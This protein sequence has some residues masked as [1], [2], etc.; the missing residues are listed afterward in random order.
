MKLSEVDLPGQ[1]FWMFLRSFRLRQPI[2]RFISC[3]Y[4]ST[5]FYLRN[6]SVPFSLL[7]LDVKQ[8]IL[9]NEKKSIFVV[10]KAL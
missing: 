6:T 9:R 7:L 10:P 2:D 3:K 8:C 5:S 1:T 4:R